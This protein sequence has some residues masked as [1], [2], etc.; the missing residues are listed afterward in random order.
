M[1][2]GCVR[3]RSKFTGNFSMVN[4][5]EKFIKMATIK[6]HKVRNHK[7][8]TLS[9]ENRGKTRCQLLDEPIGW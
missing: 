7:I 9:V 1:Y 6:R 3:V 4:I 5:Y 2:A 8:F